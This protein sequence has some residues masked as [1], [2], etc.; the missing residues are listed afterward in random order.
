MSNY[1]E[2]L[3]LTKI[4][5]S[6]D[7]GVITTTRLTREH[8]TDPTLREAFS[9]VL[10][11]VEQYGATPSVSFLQEM[12]EFSP[13]DSDD[14]LEMAASRLH[15]KLL[16]NDILTL[17]RK[18]QMTL[19]Q[20]GRRA[21]S[22]L[23]SGA[24]ILVQ[25]HVPSEDSTLSDSLDTVMESYRKRSA[26]SSGETGLIGKPWLW[27]SLN[28][29]TAGIRDDDFIVIIGQ[30]KSY[31]SWILLAELVHIYRTT[32]ARVV[33][34]TKEMSKETVMDRLVC[35]YAGLPWGP[36]NS[37]RLSAEQEDR[38]VA[39]V[40]ELRISPPVHVVEITGTGM[41]A[42]AELRNK[43]KQYDAQVMA[44]DGF[45]FLCQKQ[46]DWK[47][48]TE[49]TRA[50]RQLNLSLKIPFIVVHQANAN[51]DAAY[52]RSFQQDV[53]YMVRITVENEHRQ[54]REGFVDFPFVRDH[55]PEPLLVHTIPGENFG[56]KRAEGAGSADGDGSLLDESAP[57]NSLLPEEPDGSP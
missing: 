46:G 26:G 22:V 53:T 57:D 14:T 37:G 50:A 28:Q 29:A 44:V 20:G 34:A 36:F 47:E 3:A 41:D 12:V 18:T 52:S 31:K 38:L 27:P 15:D 13:V 40:E 32:G 43:A 8:F 11:H 2:E 6:G 39:A 10:N 16:D 17:M 25:K 23:Q 5:E 7:P 54:H 24:E 56:E 4:L 9:L 30:A 21:L 49:L 1:T 55:R 19:T 42:L 33:L 45:Y 51:N 35:L 48:L